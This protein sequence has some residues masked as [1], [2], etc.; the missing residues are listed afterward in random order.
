[1][2][3]LII[4]ITFISSFI[5]VAYS[6]GRS[7]ANGL[8]K[9]KIKASIKFITENSYGPSD[10]LGKGSKFILNQIGRRTYN[11][12]GDEIEYAVYNKNA[13]LEEKFITKYDD[14]RKE[15]EMTD[16]TYYTSNSDSTLGSTTIY[17]YDRNGN[18]IQIIDLNTDGN[19]FMKSSCIYNNKN[20]KIEQETYDSKG[21]L[22]S[23]IKNIF[24]EKNQVIET[25]TN[26]QNGT[27][28]LTHQYGTNGNEVYRKI[29]TSNGNT[30]FCKY[31]YDKYDLNGNWL[32]KTTFINGETTG[33]LN[34]TIEYY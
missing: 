2:K 12:K 7:G 5:M 10:E 24:N 32:K 20:N 22:I 14:T 29:Y 28:K 13:K 11:T 34:R 9:K 1:M 31:V 3:R 33:I 27:S 25:D 19:L 15:I 21:K 26:N 18:K 6:Q 30:T 8:P 16:Y 4:S 23:K 17:K